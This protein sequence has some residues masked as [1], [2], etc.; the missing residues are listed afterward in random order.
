MAQLSLPSPVVL[1]GMGGEG[2]KPKTK[3]GRSKKKNKLPG[4]SAHQRS[5]ADFFS[6]NIT[7]ILPIL[8]SP[9]LISVDREE[10][11]LCEEAL[12]REYRL[13][14]ASRL[15][16]PWCYGMGQLCENVRGVEPVCVRCEQD[17]ECSQSD[18]QGVSGVKP[19]GSEY[20]HQ[21]GKV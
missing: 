8:P 5:V 12:E 16:L 2:A 1:V 7:K 14:R 10:Y 3:S 11:L 15:K 18:G 13:A 6:K 17:S 19:S 9:A 21:S 4:V 20:I